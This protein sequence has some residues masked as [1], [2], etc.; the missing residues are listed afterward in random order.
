MQ[1]KPFLPV[2]HPLAYR[3]LLETCRALAWTARRPGGALAPAA[4]HALLLP[5]HGMLCFPEEE[6]RGQSWRPHPQP[7]DR[8]GLG[9]SP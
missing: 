2:Q 7:P 3:C 9:L 4:S 5:L 8:E 6:G 1:L